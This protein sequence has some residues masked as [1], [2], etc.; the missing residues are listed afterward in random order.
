M[1]TGKDVDD[2]SEVRAALEWLTSLDIR[3]LAFW[4]R[5]EAAQESYRAATSDPERFAR[6]ISLADLGG[7]IVGSYFAQGQALLSDRRSFDL[8]LASETIPWIKQLGVNLNALRPIK[9]AGDRA[10]RMLRTPEQNPASAMMELVIASNYAAQGLSVEFL[11]EDKGV[12]RTPEMRLGLPGEGDFFAVE[13]KRLQPG[14]YEARE[15]AAQL[16]QVEAAKAVIHA[17]RL[18]V[19]VD[20]TYTKELRDVPPGYLAD[21]IR[22]AQASPIVTLGSY[23]WKDAFGFGSVRPADVGAVR[24]DISDSDLYLGTKM[25]RLLTGNPAREQHFNLVVSADASRV[26]PR[27][28]R[29]VRYASVIT[30]ECTSS[31]SLTRRSRHVKAKFHEA[32]LQLRG[33]GPGIVHIAMEVDLQEAVSD[34]RRERNKAAL[35]EYKAESQVML[36][37]LHYLVPRSGETLAWLID[38]TVDRFSPLPMG[39]DL[40]MSKIF[41]TATSLG[42]DLPAWKQSPP[43]GF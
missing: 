39:A 2:D 33:H 31:E 38:E 37:Y 8:A 14:L 43:I 18:S 28:I 41:T 24:Q 17:S 12:A 11:E 29:H 7:D 13:C 3:P 22:K 19:H 25:C 42:N 35:A 15:R 23:P 26:D 20:V 21:W 32:D 5:L 40:P 34:M 30:W 10:R 27:F 36:A 6:G 1:T 16:E 4:R 9:G